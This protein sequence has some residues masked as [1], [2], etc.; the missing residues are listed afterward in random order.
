[1]LVKLKGRMKEV[2]PEKSGISCFLHPTSYF[3]SLKEHIS[4]RV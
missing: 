4:Y 1:M 3:R 2:S